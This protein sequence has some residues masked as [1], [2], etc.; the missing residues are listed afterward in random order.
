MWAIYLARECCVG[1]CSNCNIMSVK[2]S[3]V[4]IVILEI[5]LNAVIYACWFVQYGVFGQCKCT[6]L[7]LCDTLQRR[8]LFLLLNL[9]KV[10]IK[11]FSIFKFYIT[12]QVVG[13]VFVCVVRSFTRFML[14][15]NV[16]VSVNQLVEG[17]I[18]GCVIKLEIQKLLMGC[19][20]C[21]FT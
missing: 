17:N 16:V 8:R 21:G 4:M 18:K 9:S 19:R 5:V 3:P 6:R 11:Y 10:H 14:K 2:R 20:R 12:Y 13:C 1:V 7:P 15:E